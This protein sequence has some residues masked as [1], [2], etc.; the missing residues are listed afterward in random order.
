M[1]LFLLKG[2]EKELTSSRPPSFQEGSNFSVFQQLAMLAGSCSMAAALV[3][4]SGTTMAGGARVWLDWRA[5][6]GGGFGRRSSPGRIGVG[7]RA[8]VRLRTKY[9][10]LFFSKERRWR[11]VGP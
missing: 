1:P 6:G 3:P 11:Q 2:M 9:V 10:Y 7:E 5:R 8:C 4:S